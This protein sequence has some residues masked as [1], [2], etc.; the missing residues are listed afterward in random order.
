MFAVYVPLK[1]QL[2]PIA[3]DALETPTSQRLG[4]LLVAYVCR[5]LA[6]GRLKDEFPL[7]LV[8]GRL[9]GP[10]LD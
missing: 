7:T 5:T 10:I 4:I 6:G 2:Q 9:P 3:D 1:K 8:H